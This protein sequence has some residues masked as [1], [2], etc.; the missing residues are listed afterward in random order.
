MARHGDPGPEPESST[1]APAPARRRALAR[2][3][4]FVPVAVVAL[5]AA[6]AYGVG[7]RTTDEPNAKEQAAELSATVK[8]AVDKA[9]DDAAARP[10][11]AAVSYQT[12]APSL[13]VVQVERAG[14]TAGDDDI[15]GLGTGV[16]INDQGAILTAHH[17]DRRRPPI[18][19]TFADGTAPPRRSWPARTPD[20]DIAVL[21]RRQRL[22][23]VIVPAVLGGGAPG[24]RRGRIRG[25][26]PARAH[27]LAQRRRRL[28]PRPHDPAPGGVELEGLIQF[29]AA[30][31]PGNSGGP[32]LTAT[33]RWSASSPPSPTRRSRAP[34]SASA[35]PCP[36]ARPPAAPAGGPAPDVITTSEDRP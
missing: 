4:P 7:A 17:V 28:R 6:G 33:A 1:D 29:D 16:I 26:P 9:L 32:L 12:I 34:S 5:V 19:V 22:P 23:E 30:V 10:A 11:D 15:G 35:S 13:V 31:N 2:L 20:K 3:R 36:S 21:H 27:R 25:R 8:T 24:R 18:T 14:A